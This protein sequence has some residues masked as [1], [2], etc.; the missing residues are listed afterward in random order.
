MLILNNVVMYNIVDYIIMFLITLLK[1]HRLSFLIGLKINEI[2]HSILTYNIDTKI[3]INGVFSQK[4]TVTLALLKL[5]ESDSVIR[6]NFIEKIFE[7]LLFKS[8]NSFLTTA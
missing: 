6:L 5:N 4:V 7:Y 1:L 8:L 3:A 2:T